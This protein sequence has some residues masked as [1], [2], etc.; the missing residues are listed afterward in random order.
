MRIV[1][2]KDDGTGNGYSGPAAAL[3]IAVVSLGSAAIGH[4]GPKVW[5]KV[6]ATVKAKR[7]ARRR[8]KQ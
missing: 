5:N 3:G 1:V 8:L 2:W 4:F 7:E 6:K